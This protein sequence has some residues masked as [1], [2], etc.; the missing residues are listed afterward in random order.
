MGLASTYEGKHATF[1]FWVWLTSH[2]MMLSS[3]IHLPANNI[4]SFF[5]MADLNSTVYTYYIFLFFNKFLL[6]YTHYTG[7]ISSDNLA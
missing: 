6:G 1:D 2:K 5:F 3:F 4:I 7:R